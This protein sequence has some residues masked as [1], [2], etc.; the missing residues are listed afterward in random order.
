M[1]DDD[2]DGGVGVNVAGRMS[3]ALDALGEAVEVL[4]ML[5]SMK[6]KVARKCLTLF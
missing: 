6:N 4:H 2:D 5:E 1:S 3:V